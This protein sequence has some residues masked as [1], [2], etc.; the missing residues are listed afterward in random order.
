MVVGPSNESE[1]FAHLSFLSRKLCPDMAPM[2]KIRATSHNLAVLEE[3]HKNS[4]S[5]YATVPK[6]KSYPQPVD[7]SEQH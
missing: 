3:I 1:T 7:Y 6:S 5:L 4:V 2:R